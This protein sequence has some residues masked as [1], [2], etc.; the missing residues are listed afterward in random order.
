MKIVSN[1][2]ED[3]VAAGVLLSKMH[4]E[5]M[6]PK[7]WGEGVLKLCCVTV[8]PEREFSNGRTLTVI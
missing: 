7:P 4:L 1:S 2:G 5:W 3:I 8:A 6:N